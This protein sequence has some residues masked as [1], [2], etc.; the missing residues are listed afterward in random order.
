MDIFQRIAAYQ[1]ESNSL[2]WNGTF[3]DYIELLAKDPSPA[4]TAHA[5]GPLASD[6]S[7]CQGV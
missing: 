4:M 7:A 2:A 1:A 3:K 6:D 5:Q